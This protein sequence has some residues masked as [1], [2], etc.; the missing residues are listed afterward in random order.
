MGGP[1]RPRMFPRLQRVALENGAVQSLHRL[2]HLLEKHIGGHSCQAGS[3][4]RFPMCVS[5][6]IYIYIYM[7]VCIYIYIYTY[8][9]W[10]R[11]LIWWLNIRTPPP[12]KGERKQQPSHSTC[13]GKQ[14]RRLQQYIAK[15]QGARCLNLAVRIESAAQ[16]FGCAA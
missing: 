13:D 15:G 5:I 14:A 6:C 10:F 7:Y 9:W 8:T 1:P 3:F 12:K 16:F 11:V 4:L 2:L